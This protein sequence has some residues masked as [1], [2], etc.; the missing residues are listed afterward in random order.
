MHFFNWIKVLMLRRGLPFVCTLSI[1]MFPI[2]VPRSNSNVEVVEIAN[3]E[4]TTAEEINQEATN[5][6]IVEDIPNSPQPRVVQTSTVN[7]PKLG[8]VIVEARE[9]ISEFPKMVFISKFGRVLSQSSI[10]DSRGWLKPDFNG[11]MQPELRYRVLYSSDF[12]SPVIMSVAIYHGGSDSAYYLT[13]FAEVDG[14]IVRL[15]RKPVFANIQGGFYIGHLN[16]ELGFGL[17]A[18]TFI[19]GDGIEEGHYSDHRYEIDLYNFNDGKLVHTAH[20]ITRHMYECDKNWK[21]LR[22]LGIAARD[23]RTGIP[24]F[25]E[26]LEL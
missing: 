19:W 21:A 17:A 25:K 7:F 11:G 5:V 1:G 6:N 16:K 4:T 10:E 2:I 22:E 8:K 12:D 18:W 3:V 13:V 15:N 14:K 26:G 20:K 9:Q 23:Q 24:G